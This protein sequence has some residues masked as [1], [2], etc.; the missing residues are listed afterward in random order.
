[1]NRK[2][3]LILLLVFQA[4]VSGCSRTEPSNAIHFLLWKPHQPKPLEAAIARFERE[5]PDIRVERHIASENASEYYRELSTKL[6]NS[7]PDLDVFFMDVIWPPEFSARNYLEDLSPSFPPSAQKDFFPG[8]ISASTIDGRIYAVPFNIDVGLL[9]YRKDLLEKHGFSA[10]ETWPELLRQIDTILKSEEREN[11]GL[12]GYAGQFEKYEG[13]VCNILEFIGGNGGSF[14]DSGNQPAITD[15]KVI[16]AVRFIRDELLH[17]TAHPR[18]ASDYL[19]TAKE[20]QSRD[21]F[22]RGEA[23]FLRNWPETWGI[24]NDASRSSVQGRVGMAPLP[25]FKGWESIGTL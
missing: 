18:R 5:N 12:T 15:P 23:V 1:M 17:S 19:L 11:P 6:R 24:L 4:A 25:H 10:P 3:V 2:L 21:V 14:L 22:A 13:L 16:E 8:P 9:F 7:D 20:Q